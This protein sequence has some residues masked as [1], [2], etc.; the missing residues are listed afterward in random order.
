L[1]DHL[2]LSILLRLWHL[3]TTDHPRELRRMHSKMMIIKLMTWFKQLIV[4][5]R[6]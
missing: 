1:R 6:H 3:Q 2:V 5:F 4:T